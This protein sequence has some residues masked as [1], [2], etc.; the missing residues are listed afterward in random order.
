MKSACPHGSI[1]STW[2]DQ[3]QPSSH[4]PRGTDLGDPLNESLFGPAETTGAVA[5]E[6][7]EVAAALDD[8]HFGCRAALEVLKGF[9][10]DERV[11]PGGEN[12]SGHRDLAHHREGRSAAVIVHGIGK[13]PGWRGDQLVK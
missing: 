6:K 7:A 12:E 4:S 2:T 5:A 9:D 13:A 11:V 1:I 10:G 3:M 8:V